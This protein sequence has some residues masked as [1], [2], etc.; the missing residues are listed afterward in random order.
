MKN[1]HRMSGEFYRVGMS[2]STKLA[3]NF[4]KAAK[5]V[6]IFRVAGARDYLWIPLSQRLVR[7][8]PLTLRVEARYPS[9]GYE[10]RFRS[11]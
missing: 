1:L 11:G 4:T 9:S 8:V 3:G 6:S 5:L 10:Y 2:L 7:G